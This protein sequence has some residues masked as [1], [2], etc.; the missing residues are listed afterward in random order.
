MTNNNYEEGKSEVEDVKH[1]V[2]MIADQYPFEPQIA[3]LIELVANCLDAKASEIIINFDKSNGILR[4]LDNGFG[5]DN[6][7]F[8]KYHNLVTTAKIRGEAIGFVGQGAKI[9]LNFCRKIITETR[10]KSYKGYSVWQLRGNDAP[11]QIYH[12]KTLDL[13]Y[14]GTQ[15]ELFLDNKSRNFYNE[16]LIKQVLQEHYF[17]L[18]DSRLLKA[19]IGEVPILADDKTS[20][21]IYKPIYEKGLIF[22]INGKLL[23]IKPIQNMI[24]NQ[25]DISITVYRK[26]KAKGFFGLLKEEVAE[27]L[28]GVAICAF[29]KV[30][31]RTWFKKEPLEKQRIIGWIEAPYLIKAVT[32]DKCRFQKGNKTWESF[33]RKTQIKFSRWLEKSDLLEV[34][35]RRALDY[36]NLEKEINSILKNIP[37]LTFFGSKYQR[38]VSISNINGDQRTIGEGT[39]KVPGTKGGETTGEGVSIYPGDE[40][41]EAPTLETGNGDT[42]IPKRRTVRGGIRITEDERPDLDKEAWFDGE[43]VTMNKSH[44]AYMKAKNTRLLNY[45]FLKAVIMSLIEFSLE[46]EQEASYQ[47]VLE[48]QQKFFKTWGE[49]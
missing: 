16:D 48:L 32:T 13:N 22:I 11:Y 14:E 36:I 40:F 28:P 7:Q 30:V 9:A 33:F 43:T 27:V 37:E 3:A 2:Q 20:L 15:V 29:G 1:F 25:N 10:S 24:D 47:R 5:M 23:T 46:K 26:P 19:Y 35:K 6:T 17:P 41:G 38:D 12:N 18:L 44:P 49:L 21:K 8:K 39:Q 31:E 34:P 45:H 42:A 4:V